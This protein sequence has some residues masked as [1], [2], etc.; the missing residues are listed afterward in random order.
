MSTT[1]THDRPDLDAFIKEVRR[2]ANAQ[3][4]TA[5]HRRLF[6]IPLTI[7][8]ARVWELQMAFWTLN[9]RDC[10]AFA[11]GLVPFDVKALIWEHEEDELSGNKG[12]GVENHYALHVDQGRLLGLTPE[13]Y[14][15]A[16]MHPGTRT[17][18]YA[19]IH[20]VK[21]SHWLKAVSACACLE[22]SNSSDWV[23]GGG[24]S[25][26]RGKLYE[27][28]LGIP[29]E[30]QVS[31]K[32]HAEVDVEHANMLMQVAHRYGTSQQALDLMLEGCVESWEIETVWKAQV[33]DMMEAV[34]YEPR[35]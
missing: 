3:Y 25:Y 12:R 14:R 28:Q 6:G 24:N 5:Q 27:Q 31:H 22:V 13:D 7:E 23:D 19:W 16:Q 34:P 2:R 26:R 10:W 1:L 33:G 15:N 21:D 32:E 4:A 29:F 17:C 18:T 8:R 30:K 11:Q 35:R 20:L 9:R